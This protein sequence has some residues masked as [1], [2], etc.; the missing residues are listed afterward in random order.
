LVLERR[1]IIGGIAATEEIFPG[2]K[3]ST[4]AHLA[5]SFSENIVNDLNLRRYGL[6][7]LPLNP[8]LFAPAPDGDSLLLSQDEAKNADQIGRFSRTDAVRFQA[9]NALVKKLSAFLNTLNGLPMPDGSHAERL[10]ATELIKAGWKFRR[11]GKKEMHEFL[12]ILPMSVAD[13]LNEWFETDLLKAG[14]AAGALLGSFVGPRAQGTSFT[15]LHHQLGASTGAL[16][17]AGIVRGGIGNLPHAVAQ[18]ARHH[19]AEIRT[20]AEVA[21]IVT[22]NGTAT[23]VVLQNG[24]EITAHVVVSNADVKRTFF[25]LLEPTYL[26]PR[27][28]L[29]VKNIRSRGTVAKLNFALDALPRFKCAS[30]HALPES[31]GGVVHI[32]PTLDYLEHAA[33]DAKYGRFSSEPLLEISLPSVTDSSLAPPGKHVMSVWMQYAPYHLKNGD[34]E[35]QRDGLGATVVETIEQYAPGFRNSILHHCLLTPVDLEQT[36]ALTEGHPYHAELALDQIF[37]M[38]PVPGRARYRTP[39]ENLYLCGSGTHPGGGITGLPGYYAA[40]T[41]LQS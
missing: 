15:L 18:G 29:Q 7:I 12:R 1:P 8:L 31:L 2:F 13:L 25:K 17:T 16:R 32:G 21:K 20:E 26:D 35:K 40:K 23:G 11:L 28:L 4:C 22:K 5:G 41:I 9:F 33:D 14:L 24:E 3:Y 34:W 39:I 19:G 30:D 36:F 10:D 6:E 38:R 27:F 37:F